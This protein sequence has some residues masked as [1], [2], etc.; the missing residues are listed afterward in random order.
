MC[1]TIS[2][3]ILGTVI[4]AACGFMVFTTGVIFSVINV[5]TVK[6]RY[7]KIAEIS[8][9][10]D[11]ILHSDKLVLFEDTEE[12]EFAVLESEIKKMTMRLREN[13]FLLQQE[14]EFLTDS[15]AD[16]AHQ[17]RTPL[18][19]I[20]LIMSFMRKQDL[21]TVDRLRYVN[22]INKHLNRIDWL[23]SSLL[24]ISKIDAGTA[25]FKK[26][27]VEVASVI[28]KAIEPLLIPFEIR[29]QLFDFTSFGNE[30]FVGDLNWTAEAVGNIIK[31][32]SEHTGNGGHIAVKSKENILYTEITIEDNGSGIHED[33][34]PHLFERFYQGKSSA[35]SSVGI[36]L[37]LTRMIVQAQNGSIK[38]ENR[39]IKGSR[40][41]IKFYKGV[42]HEHS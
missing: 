1:V 16:I 15:I 27:T 8:E 3:T 26:E 38:V 41:I 6:E 40:F 28:S 14:K 31:N 37:A 12:G 2:L 35:D 25:N 39:K 22:E 7:E 10:V 30:T 33:D 20:N 24:K 29:D 17:L 9:M 18:T 23:I 42:D 19:T 11:M 4:H 36:G 34:L 5:L 32:C 21:E 13:A